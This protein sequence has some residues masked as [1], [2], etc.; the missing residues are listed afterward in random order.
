[1][2]GITEKQLEDALRKQSLSQ[3]RA[4][5]IVFNALL[6][7]NTRQRLALI[8]RLKDTAES[9][10]HDDPDLTGIIADLVNELDQ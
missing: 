1:M 6:A 5:A 2:T 10:Q 9:P 3:T 8:S 7:D 4:Y